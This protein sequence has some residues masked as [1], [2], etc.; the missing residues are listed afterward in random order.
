M[1]S[2]SVRIQDLLVI[3]LE[4]SEELAHLPE[5]T[6]KPFTPRKKIPFSEVVMLQVSDFEETLNI[7]IIRQ[8]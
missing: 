7:V 6:N 2:P 1:L 4:D 3:V 5:A 8:T